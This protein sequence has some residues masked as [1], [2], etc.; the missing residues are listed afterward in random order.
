M[1]GTKYLF[2]R[3]RASEEWSSE[4]RNHLHPLPS[5]SSHLGDDPQDPLRVAAASPVAGHQQNHHQEEDDG[6]DRDQY[7]LRRTP[8][9]VAG[10]WAAAHSECRLTLGGGA[11]S[12]NQGRRELVTGRR[13]LVTGKKGARGSG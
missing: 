4:G 5:Q 8:T 13:E 3:K 9:R 7:G 10:G 1:H 2:T 12:R 11:H 6:E